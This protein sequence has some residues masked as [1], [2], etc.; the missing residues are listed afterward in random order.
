MVTR[1]LLIDY[2]IYYRTLAPYLKASCVLFLNERFCIDFNK[3]WPVR[4]KSHRLSLHFS[5]LVVLTHH[6]PVQ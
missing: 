6:R 4:Q 2:I 1:D 3:S 5:S